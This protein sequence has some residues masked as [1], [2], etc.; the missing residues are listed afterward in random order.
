MEKIIQ[1]SLERYDFK[2]PKLEFIRHNENITYKVLDELNTYVL[3]VHKPIEGFSLGIHQRDQEIFKYIESEMQLIDYAKRCMNTPIQKPVKNKMGEFVSVLQD[4]TCVTVLEWVQGDTIN[5]IP[6]TETIGKTIGTM[7]AELHKCFN[8]LENNEDNRPVKNVLNHDIK[9]YMYDQKMLDVI[10]VELSLI[11]RDGLMEKDKVDIMK[12]AVRVIKG[13]MDELD[14][15]QNMSGIVHADLSPSNLI[16]SNEKIVPIDFS[17][18]GY[19]FYYMDIGLIVSQYKDNNIKRSIVSGYEE[20]MQKEI[21][22][23]Y[24][25]AFIALGVILF[26]VCQYDKVRTQDWFDGAV[27]RWCETIFNPLINGKSFVYESN[28]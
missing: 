10:E 13:I 5:N 22:L 18:S 7:I 26:I 6:M 11:V 2:N 8:E 9:R 4:G 3:R 1:E 16:F 20:T 21:P 27:K 12:D 17:L 15:M 25:E 19:G 23:R 24:I 28:Q 14:E